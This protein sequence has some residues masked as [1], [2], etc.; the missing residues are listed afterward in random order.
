M[1]EKPS[2]FTRAKQALDESV[3]SHADTVKTLECAVET[4]EQLRARVAEL[5]AELAAMKGRENWVTLVRTRSE[6]HDR[7]RDAIAALEDMVDGDS[8]M[9]TP[10]SMVIGILEGRPHG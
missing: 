6:A 7:I 3:A 8:P 5:E 10:I 4:V 9:D 2:M 1:S